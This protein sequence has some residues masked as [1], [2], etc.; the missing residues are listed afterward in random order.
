MAI[1]GAFCG[2]PAIAEGYQAAKMFPIGN[3]CAQGDLSAFIQGATV[4]IRLE[5]TADLIDP[6]HFTRSANL[7]RIRR[8]GF[9]KIVSG[10]LKRGTLGI[11]SRDFFNESDVALRHLAFPL[12]R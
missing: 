7:S 11:A 2:L 3:I 5:T 12:S 8:Q 9:G 10:F 6:V 1:T 4:A